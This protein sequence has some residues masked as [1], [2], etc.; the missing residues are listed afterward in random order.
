[1]HT[2]NKYSIV[3]FVCGLNANVPL[4]N[5]INSFKKHSEYSHEYVDLTEIK[6]RLHELGEYEEEFFYFELKRGKLYSWF[7]FSSNVSAYFDFFNEILDDDYCYI[8]NTEYDYFP[9]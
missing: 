9:K 4:E 5:L 1:M 7:S 3:N 6:D 2:K 8:V